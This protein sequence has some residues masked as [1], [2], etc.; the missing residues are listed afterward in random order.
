[1]L[2]KIEKIKPSNE[3]FSTEDEITQNRFITLINSILE[4]SGDKADKIIDPMKNLCQKHIDAQHKYEGFDIKEIFEKTNEIN[5]ATSLA[6]KDLN[7]HFMLYCSEKD[8]NLFLEIVEEKL[9]PQ[10]LSSPAQPPQ[11]R[12]V[13][14]S[15]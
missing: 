11:A 8:L 5:S 7:H 15:N 9:C 1:M 12:P 6:V 3:D 4:A 14:P 13:S 10:F 2:N